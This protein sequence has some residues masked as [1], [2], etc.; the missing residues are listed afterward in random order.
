MKKVQWFLALMVLL[1]ACVGSPYLAVKPNPKLPENG[2][3]CPT[4]GDLQGLKPVATP[5]AALRR[6]IGGWVVL[7]Y[8]VEA[9]QMVNIKVWDSS[10]SGLYDKNM[11]ASFESAQTASAIFAKGCYYSQ[12]F[13]L[14]QRK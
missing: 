8:D 10:P 1:C 6:G 2:A 5:K 9:G 13:T 12:S 11:V 4:M 7:Q 14:L 3:A